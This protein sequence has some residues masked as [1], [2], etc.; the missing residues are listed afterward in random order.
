MDNRSTGPS[1]FL[2][3]PLF[4]YLQFPV[5]SICYGIYNRYTILFGYF[6]FKQESSSKMDIPFLNQIFNIMVHTLVLCIEPSPV[7]L[8]TKSSVV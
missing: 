4:R 8:I 3:T 2:G 6:T 7:I 5:I 1:L